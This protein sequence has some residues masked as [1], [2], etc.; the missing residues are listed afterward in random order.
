MDIDIIVSLEI[1]TITTEDSV[2]L[3]LQK[4]SNAVLKVNNRFYKTNV[5]YV[6]KFVTK[7]VLTHI[8]KSY[9]TFLRQKFKIRDVW[10][11]RKRFVG[12]IYTKQFVWQASGM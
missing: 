8:L 12:L 6:R 4:L 7:Y 10:K 11:I 1:D 2:K 9:D 3:S 5:R